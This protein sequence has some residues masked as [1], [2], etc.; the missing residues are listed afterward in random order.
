[1][2]LASAVSAGVITAVRA[3]PEFFAD[4]GDPG[5]FP[6]SGSDMSGFTLERATPESFAADMAALVQSSSRVTLREPAVAPPAPEEAHSYVPDP[7][8][9]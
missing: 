5:S 3:W 1:M 8:W 7:E 4:D 9:T 6:A 2:I